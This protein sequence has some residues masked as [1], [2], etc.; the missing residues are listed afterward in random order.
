MRKYMLMLMFMHISMV[1]WHDGSWGVLE[2]L[3][4]DAR[5]LKG[6]GL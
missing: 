1:L 2:P 6:E 4:G 5:T 3:R